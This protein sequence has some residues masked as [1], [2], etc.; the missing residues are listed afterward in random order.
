MKNA[1]VL[2]ALFVALLSSTICAAQPLV[3][4]AS[5]INVT[6]GMPI[7]VASYGLRSIAS[8]S[9]PYVIETNEIFGFANISSIYAYNASP[10]QNVSQYGASLQLNAMLN[11][12]S[13][14]EYYT[15]WAQDTLDLNTSNDTY[16]VIDNVW[17]VTAPGANLSN[18]TIVGLGNVTGN[19]VNG[20][21]YSYGTNM[22]YYSLPFRFEPVM[23]LSYNHGYPYLQFGYAQNGSAVFYDNTTLLIPNSTA[24]FLVTPYNQ[25]PSD[26]LPPNS[27]NYYDAELVFGGEADGASANFSMMRSM[28]WIGYLNNGTIVPFPTAATFGADTGEVATNLT[29]AQGNGYAIVETGAPDYHKTIS[30]SGVPSGITPPLPPVPPTVPTTTIMQANLGSVG[31]TIY[32]IAPI[33]ILVII[34]LLSRLLMRRRNNPP[35]PLEPQQTRA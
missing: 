33:A 29:V 34:G 30:L 28:L 3:N 4:P 22:S 1:L 9:G 17:N 18:G 20:T 11:V 15:Y 7:G 19:A 5:F 35:P 24:Y 12:S 27:T 8:N 31:S 2:A 10:A 21:F 16:S 14:G 25:A 32:Y 23:R 13:N 26:G 6:N